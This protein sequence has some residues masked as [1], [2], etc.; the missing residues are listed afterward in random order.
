MQDKAIPIWDIKM[1]SRLWLSRIH[2]GNF[3][4]IKHEALIP[5]E[6]NSVANPITSYKNYMF[7]HVK[8]LC[9]KFL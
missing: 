3:L 5:I 1:V 8:K 6:S 2:V 4:M 9:H 7:N